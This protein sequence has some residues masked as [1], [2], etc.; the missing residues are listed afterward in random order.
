MLECLLVD[1]PDA[2]I[3]HYTE[4]GWA[5]AG[6][7]GFELAAQGPEAI[8]AELTR[9]R[10]TAGRT[11]G[12]AGAQAVFGKLFKWVHNTAY[13]EEIGAIREVLKEAIL[14]NFPIG[15]GEMLF[16]DPVQRRYV[17]SAN[18]LI[19]KTGRNRLRFYKLLTKLGVI[20]E[21]GGTIAANQY[22]FPAAE[23]ELLVSRIENS[24][25]LNKVRDILGCS[26]TNEAA[27]A[28]AGLISSVVPMAE[29][30]AVGLTIG[31]YNRDDLQE[32]LEAVCD[33]ASIVESV[34]EGFENFATTSKRVGTAPIVSWQRDSQLKKTVMLRGE[35]RFD[36]LYFDVCEIKAHCRAD[37][38]SAIF[39]L[40]L[41]AK[42][43]KTQAKVLKKLMSTEGGGPLIQRA[44][45]EDCKGLAGISY[46]TQSEI[47]RFQLVY[48]SLSILSKETGIHPIHLRKGLEADGV[49]PVVDP[50]W[51][52][53]RIY[54]RADLAACK[55]VSLKSCHA[56]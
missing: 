1:G 4:A 51:L 12:R 31:T 17:H 27:L 34:P 18:T 25:H 20:P 54:R 39:R 33:K 29:S 52:G 38:A 46:V 47:D 8:I 35:R 24:V 44:P 16:G 15:P 6:D 7:M 23:A 9:I 41:A 56:A 22:V 48:V 19:N 5:R 55:A 42:I 11:S 32:L 50:V 26:K 40:S 3:I 53:A 30:S 43:L 2:D 28:Q 49:E 14:W 45:A 10:S 13:G 21:G 36:R 37:R